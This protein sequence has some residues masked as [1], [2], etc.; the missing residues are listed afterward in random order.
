MTDNGQPNF[1]YLNRDNCWADFEWRNLELGE[2]GALR[3]ASLPVLEG[4]LPE[5]IANVAI[6]T[7]PSGVA[8][9]PDGTIY[10]SDTLDHRIA[11]VDACDQQVRPLP[12]AGGEGTQ[13]SQL[14]E[15]R[16]LLWHPRRGVLFVADS[17]N[18]RIQLFDLDSGQLRGIWG[19]PDPSAPPLPGSEPGRLNQ[20][21]TLAADSD[22]NVY[23]VDAGNS[24]VQKFDIDGDIISSFWELMQQQNPWGH[25]SEVAVLGVGKETEVFVFDSALRVVVTLDPEGHL[26]RTARIPS[27]QQPMGFAV[28]ADAFYFGENARR[29][30]LK[31]RHD[32]EYVG[33]AH[34]YEGPVAALALDG[35][36]GLLVH[37]GGGLAPVRLALWGAFVHGHTR[38][39]LW[40]GPFS[41]KSVRQRQWHRLKAE[42]E[43]LLP[44]AHVQL[45]VYPARTAAL[46]P[47]SPADTAG[48]FDTTSWKSIGP[49]DALE[50]LF[51]GAPLDFMWV[52]TELTSEGLASPV[53]S[54]MRLDFDHVSY[55]P[56]LPPVY[57]EDVGSYEFLLRFLSIFESQFDDVESEIANLS[58]LFDP[59][60]VSADLPWLASCV[61]AELDETWPEEMKR[62]AITMAFASH[63]RRGTAQGLRQALH[64]YAAVD[65]RIEEPLAHAAWWALPAGDDVSLPENRNSTLGF[66]TMLAAT[67]PQG[68]VLGTTA[69]LDQSHLIS[70]EEFGAPLFSDLAHRFLVQVY[71]GQVRCSGSLEKVRAV[72]EREKPA[73]T[74]FHLCVLEP[75]MRVGF[76]A[77][78]GVDTIV[79]SASPRGESPVSPADELV[80][81]GELPGRIGERSRVGKT[82]RLGEAA[83]R[84]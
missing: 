56:H 8:V 45:F 62:R 67:E 74:A 35:R 16:G 80:L 63:A 30:V 10:F 41:N 7:G 36:G 40:G 78:V 75:R 34:G 79:A 20:P 27:L 12:C 72:V 15:P 51:A 38:G 42:F 2:D 65:A 26:R 55:L 60:A 58:A 25:P 19:Q 14:R 44:G 9:G 6:Q 49:V 61:A 81:A 73:H 37:S 29:R 66:T 70:A 57:H 18:H 17:G 21:W 33:E 46:R 54:Q 59:E 1:L 76:Q 22:G 28:T 24:R 31:F 52:G 69:V 84:D 64:F 53:I 43:P 68:A 23:V 5:E 83:L 3:L 71:R 13:T 48:K 39:L 50:G 32:G 77:S 4:K 82:T 47:P 11:L